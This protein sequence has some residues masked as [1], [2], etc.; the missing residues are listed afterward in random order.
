MCGIVAPFSRQR[1]ISAEGL[2][3]GTKSLHHR[4]PDGRRA[5]KNNTPD[6]RHIFLVRCADVDA[7]LVVEELRCIR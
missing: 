2:K 6:A 7:D 1:R 5:L 4:G 3:R